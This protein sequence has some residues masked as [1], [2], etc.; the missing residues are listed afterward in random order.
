MTIFLFL[1]LAAS[2]E[3]RKVRVSKQSRILAASGLAA[4]GSGTGKRTWNEMS[5]SIYWRSGADVI[6]TLATCVEG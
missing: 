4:S 5:G 6:V 1:A 2:V 3:Q